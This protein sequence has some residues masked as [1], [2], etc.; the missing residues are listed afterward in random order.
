M[1]KLLVFIFSLIFAVSAV[2][3]FSVTAFGETE[4]SQTTVSTAQ[5]LKDALLNN[6]IT[7][8]EII[9][10]ANIDL[11]NKKITGDKMFDGGSAE[12]YY[13][14]YTILKCHKV[15]GNRDVYIGVP[16]MRMKDVL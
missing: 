8:E 13:E 9:A 5:E 1:K 12:Y 4:S 15:D 16:Y 11:K 7:M 3:G 10:K 14:D 6:K 2:T